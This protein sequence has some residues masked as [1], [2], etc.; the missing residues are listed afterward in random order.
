M[1]IFV[2]CAIKKGCL[3]KISETTGL[4]AARADMGVVLD[5]KDDNTQMPLFPSFDVYC[6]KNCTVEQHYAYSLEIIS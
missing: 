5:V 2:D 1:K 3:V 4:G 6:F